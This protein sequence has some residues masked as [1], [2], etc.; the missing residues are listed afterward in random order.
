MGPV[1]ECS[2]AEELADAPEAIEMPF[3]L[4]HV[5]RCAGAKD[6]FG[7]VEDLSGGAEDFEVG[8]A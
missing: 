8:A 5:V 7:V 3:I 1:E 6:F 2:G 4:W